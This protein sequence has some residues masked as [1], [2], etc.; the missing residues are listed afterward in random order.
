MTALE[1]ASVCTLDCP[2]TCALTVTVNEGRIVKVRGRESSPSTEG[3]ICN[4]VAQDMPE[5][6]HGGARL[7]HPLRRTGP[8]GSGKFERI[9]WD[10][11]LDAIHAGLGA[12][13][14]RFGPQTVLPLNYAGPHGMLQGDSMSARFFHKLGAT[15]L[16]R[17]SLCGAVR[18]QA[19]NGM[20][21][22]VP[23]CPPE[24]CAD[25]DLNV[26]WGN[27]AT[28]ANL[29]VVR[30]IRQAKRKGGRLVAIDPLR[31]KIAGQADLHLAPRPSTDVV[32]AFSIAV[33]LERLGAIDQSFVAQNVLGYE[34]YMQRARAFP[35]ATASEI[36]G[37]PA[38]DITL[39]AQWLIE[40][41]RLVIAPGNGWERGRNGGSGV[42]AAYA[43]P[44]LL[45][46]FFPQRVIAEHLRDG[47]RQPSRIF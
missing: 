33:E 18:G 1:H 41:K 12:A 13:I 22:A 11:A 26:V 17:G 14:K 9:S 34:E 38:A 24:L 5:F 30:R 32:L 25:A 36:C 19:W 20:F 15:Q 3:V 10:D 39:F 35:P 47:F 44:A 40:A 46:K 16:F 43:L 31:T 45:G 6:V 23:G 28:V 29:H 7:L 21:G 2:D 4:K 27:N 8:K 37:V 42:R